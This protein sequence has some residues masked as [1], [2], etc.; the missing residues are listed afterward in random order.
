MENC[1]HPQNE[2]FSPIT[3]YDFQFLQQIRAECETLNPIVI[4]LLGV[5]YI[6]HQREY[7]K[8]NFIELAKRVKDGVDIENLNA[9]DQNEIYKELYSQTTLDQVFRLRWFQSEYREFQSE[10]ETK[11]KSDHP[12]FQKKDDYSIIDFLK[13]PRFPAQDKNT[14]QQNS[15]AQNPLS[16]ASY[17]SHAR[18]KSPFLILL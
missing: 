1:Q 16:K 14:P 13:T 5:N 10:L 9:F 11:V 15:C 18:G 12:S 17:P 8:E 7:P 2:K 4:F 3:G 6:R